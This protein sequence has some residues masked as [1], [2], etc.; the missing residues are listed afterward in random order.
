MPGGKTRKPQ[1]GR[2]QCEEVRAVKSE[3]SDGTKGGCRTANVQ[4]EKGDTLDT[5]DQRRAETE[6]SVRA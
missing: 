3:L 5:E 4:R 6:Y 1:T 2:R